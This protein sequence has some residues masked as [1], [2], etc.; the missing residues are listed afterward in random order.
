VTPGPDDAARER[1]GR[2][3][4]APEDAARSGDGPDDGRSRDA[5]LRAGAEA[6]PVRGPLQGLQDLA[7]IL[8]EHPPRLRSFWRGLAIGALVGA[9]IAGSAV[10]RRARRGGGPRGGAPG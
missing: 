1:S 9:A 10:W 5:D 7:T 3:G 8:E 2:S 6:P 4:D